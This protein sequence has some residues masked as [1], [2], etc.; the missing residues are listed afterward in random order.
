MMKVRKMRNRKESLRLVLV[1][2]REKD[3]KMLPTKLSTKSSWLGNKAIN[4]MKRMKKKKKIQSQRNRTNLI[5]RTILKVKMRKLMT[6]RMISKKIKSQ[7]TRM[8]LLDFR[9]LRRIIMRI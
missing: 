8:Y 7:K 6:R 2:V 9:V 3:S 1:L 4:K 5:W